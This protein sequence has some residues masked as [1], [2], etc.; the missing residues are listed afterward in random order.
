MTTQAPGTGAAYAI[1]V[2]FANFNGYIEDLWEALNL[3]KDDWNGVQVLLQDTYYPYDPRESTSC[4]LS[5]AASAD[6][7]APILL[8]QLVNG[9]QAVVGVIG[10]SSGII[11]A[12]TAGALFRYRLVWCMRNPL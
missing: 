1:L 5:R 2:S 3:S 6:N 12:P 11:G 4:E 9:L 8:R 7:L 10:A